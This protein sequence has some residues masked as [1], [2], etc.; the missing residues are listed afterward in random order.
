MLPEMPVFD[1]SFRARCPVCRTTI[2]GHLVKEK[3]TCPSCDRG[4]RSNKTAAR[5]KAMIL[6]LVLT[7]FVFLSSTHQVLL[8]LAAAFLP[9]IF[10][11]FSFKAWLRISVR[12]NRQHSDCQS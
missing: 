4:L 11:L 6:S 9:A 5:R 1:L 12:S 10:G 3:F 7:G 2:G 8:Y